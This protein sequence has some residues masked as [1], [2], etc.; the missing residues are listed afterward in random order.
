MRPETSISCRR[1]DSCRKRMTDLCWLGEHS[2][3]QTWSIAS[4]LEIAGMGQALHGSRINRE[5]RLE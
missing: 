3:L 5:Y 1:L 4:S 2:R